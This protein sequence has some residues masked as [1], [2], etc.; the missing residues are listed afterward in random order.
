MKR[1]T[2]NILI[3]LTGVVALGGAVKIMN[4]EPTIDS[5]ALVG[6]F[7][8]W[9]YKDTTYSLTYNEEHDYYEADVFTS[10]FTFG[11][12][13]KVC[14]NKNK[15]TSY[16]FDFIKTTY[17]PGGTSGELGGIKYSTSGFHISYSPISNFIILEAKSYTEDT[18]INIDNNFYSRTGINGTLCNGIWIFYNNDSHNSGSRYE[19]NFTDSLGNVYDNIT[20]AG[21]LTYS[22]VNEE[23]SI[24]FT[25]ENVDCITKNEDGSFK[26]DYYITFIEEP[27]SSDVHG[28]MALVAE[29]YIPIL[30]IH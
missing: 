28:I 16:G 23:D 11:D 30:Y 18:I 26:T 8:N 2:K 21:N 22:Q 24:Y 27:E 15:I 7:N 3:A 9:D 19:A 13:F 20:I 6:N 14:V 25:G 12:E 17:G 4:T 1:T 29:K 10:G 5:V